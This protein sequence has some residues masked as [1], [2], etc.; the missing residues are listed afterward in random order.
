MKFNRTAPTI[1]IP[2]RGLASKSTEVA[3][4]RPSIVKFRENM[5]HRPNYA[6]VCWMAAS[7]P[8]GRR[9]CRQYGQRRVFHLRHCALRPSDAI[10]SDASEMTLVQ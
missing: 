8:L 2:T 4:G 5:S 3:P 9:H 6:L 1:F 10:E 7:T